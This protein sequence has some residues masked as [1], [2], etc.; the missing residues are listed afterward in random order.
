[1]EALRIPRPTFEKNDIPDLLAYI[2]SVGGGVERIYVQPGNP[3]HGEKLFSVKRCSQCH[4]INHE[5]ARVGPNLRAR[6]KGTLMTIAGAMWNHGPKM[7][8]KM[9]ERGIEVPSLTT[10]EMSDLISYLYFLQ[11]IDPP[12]EAKRGGIVYQ[13]KRCGKCHTLPGIAGTVAPDL[14]RTERLK[15]QLDVVSEMW[16]HASTME[17]KMLEASVEWPVFRG[18]EMADLIAYLLSLR[19]AK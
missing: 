7:W 12:G 8:A 6:L 2:R 15:T 11:F 14:A 9:A 18:G 19:L 13:E 10:D 16:N 5:G 3:Q 1:M 17:Q 4:S